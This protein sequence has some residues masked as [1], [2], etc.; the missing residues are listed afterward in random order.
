MRAGRRLRGRSDELRVSLLHERVLPGL[1]EAFAQVEWE[2]AAG[3]VFGCVQD[4]EV[5]GREVKVW[6]VYEEGGEYESHYR[7]PLAVFATE[8]LARAFCEAAHIAADLVEEW[9]VLDV[10]P[11]RCTRYSWADAVTEDG[12][13]PDTFSVKRNG[14]RREQ[15]EGW[16]HEYEPLSVQISEWSGRGS[17]SRYVQVDGFDKDAVKAAFAT[18]LAE[19]TELVKNRVPVGKE[20]SRG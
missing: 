2:T 15:F 12:I 14:H 20:G 19:A 8:T 7:D 5:E 4:G 16:D 3:D 11:S 9:D 13:S 17:V 6:I 10:L 1:R 18:A